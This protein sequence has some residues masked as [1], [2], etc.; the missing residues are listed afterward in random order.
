VFK[1]FVLMTEPY[2]HMCS[3]HFTCSSGGF[4]SQLYR[5]MLIHCSVLRSLVTA[6]K[7]STRD[8]S[9]LNNNAMLSG[10]NFWTVKVTLVNLWWPVMELY[11]CIIL[12]QY[13][14]FLGTVHK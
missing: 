13:Y 8:M 2:H 5:N 3:Y 14:E 7:R 9:M 6:E 1:M 4:F 12:F 11:L 10:Q